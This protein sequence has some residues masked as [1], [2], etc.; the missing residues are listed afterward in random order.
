MKA[1]VF[2]IMQYVNHPETGEPLLSE[3][4]IKEALAHKT[5]KQWAYIL[6]D[7]DVYSEQDE[8]Q[9]PNHTTDKEKPPHWHIVL[10]MGT[11]Q[12]E[13]GVVAK[14]FGIAEN[15]VDVPKGNGAGKFLDCVEYLTHESVKQQELGKH[16]YNDSE[17][18][19]SE[20]F[21]WRAKL[22]KRNENKMKYG[23]DLDDKQ[24]MM[25]DVLYLGKTLRQCMKQNELLYMDCFEK[26]QKLRLQYISHQRP[27]KTRINYYICGKGGVGKGLI[28]RALARSMYPQYEDDEDIFFEVGA[29]GAPFEG[30]DGQ[31]VIIWN[32][33]RAFD[34]LQELNGRGNVFNV[35]DTHPTKQ[36]QNVKFSSICLCNT[37]NIVNSVQD[38]VEFLEGLAGGYTDKN[39]EEHEAEDKGQSYRRFPFIIPLHK[40]D[41]DMLLNKGFIEETDKFEEYIEHKHLIGNMQRIHSICGQNEALAKELEAKTVQPV[42]AKHNEIMDK[43]NHETMDEDAIRE[44]FKDYGT[45][46]TEPV[47]TSLNDFMQVD[48]TTELP[49]D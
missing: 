21:D 13:V 24:Q 49:F 36:R 46:R 42:I 40:D 2:N 34:L 47:Q 30:Y 8:I 15:F 25:Y 35:F 33:R 22:D 29:K 3:D 43:F 48:N 23:K 26:L 14:W 27:P 31:P 44:M 12:I 16:R 4:K 6:H 10:Q 32:D 11:N 19:A 18:I 17:V 39:G 5:I 9:D 45:Q 28:S 1:R 37:V 38:Y 7:K 20:G 41:F